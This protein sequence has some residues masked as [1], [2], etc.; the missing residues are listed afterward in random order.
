LVADGGGAL[1]CPL[2]LA[3]AV[4]AEAM[5]ENLSNRSIRVAATEENEKP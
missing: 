5:K 2:S 1:G 3:A 4:I